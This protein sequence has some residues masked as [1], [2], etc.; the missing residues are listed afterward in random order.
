MGKI[1][2]GP[3]YES[4]EKVLNK[5]KTKIKSFSNNV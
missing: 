1:H 3:D 2:D 5:W 4:Y